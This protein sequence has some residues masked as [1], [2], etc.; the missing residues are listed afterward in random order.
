MV[1]AKL[2]KSIHNV[3][4]LARDIIIHLHNITILGE[5]NNQGTKSW[6]RWASQK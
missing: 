3:A 1:K 6:V 2:S 5:V 4:K